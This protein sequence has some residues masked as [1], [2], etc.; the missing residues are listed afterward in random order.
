MKTVL[1]LLRRESLQI[2][3]LALPYVLAAA[4]WDKLPPR[5]V[6]HWGFHNQPNGW[7]P[8][9]AGLLMPPSINILITVLFGLVPRFVPSLHRGGPVA[10]VGQRRIWRAARLCQSAVFT[11]I[12]MVAAVAAAGWQL[13]IGWA[14]SMAGLILFAAIG[15][16]LANIQPNYL[17]GIR[18]P[19]T[20]DDPATWRATHRVGSRVM[21]FG[22]LALLMVGCF[23][24]GTVLVALLLGFIALLA[25]GGLGYSAWF[26][27]KHAAR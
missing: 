25:L 7:M 23:V 5:I 3:I 2:V 14:C 19:W 17:M 10:I 20:L 4:L 1:R 15:N 26:Y 27:Q 18:T 6:T 24:P 12:C 11:T 13:D 8:K 9:A 16:L 21:F 22:S